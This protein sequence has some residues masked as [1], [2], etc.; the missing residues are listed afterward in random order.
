MADQDRER[1]IAAKEKLK[2]L[3]AT[4]PHSDECKK[5]GAGTNPLHRCICDAKDKK[6]IYQ[7]IIDILE[8][9]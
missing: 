6:F 1:L 7:D 3:I 9:T 2:L 8:G 5:A 4:T